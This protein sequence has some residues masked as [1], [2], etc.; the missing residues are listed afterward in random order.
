MKRKHL[1]LA[2]ALVLTSGTA[3]MAATPPQTSDEEGC[4]CSMC[5]PG[6]TNCTYLICSD[7]TGGQCYGVYVG[8]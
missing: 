3:A 8:L 1:W 6:A 4:R 7:G 5:T 2:G